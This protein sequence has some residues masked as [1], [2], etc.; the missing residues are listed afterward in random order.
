MTQDSPVRANASPLE[1]AVDPSVCR[2][3]C[4][5]T[6]GSFAILITSAQT[7]RVLW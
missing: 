2:S 5:V 4:G 1:V 6:P 3:V 7:L